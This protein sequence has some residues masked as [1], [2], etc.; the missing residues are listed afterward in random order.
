[1]RLNPSDEYDREILVLAKEIVD[2]DNGKNDS[3]IKVISFMLKYDWERC[4]L[5]SRFFKVFYEVNVNGCG[6]L[7]KNIIIDDNDVTIN[8]VMKGCGIILYQFFIFCSV[9]ISII[10]TVM[11]FQS[12]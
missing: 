5:E 10:S 11:Y 9:V 3:F 2:G 6:R 8:I 1:M 7:T 4:K 12:R